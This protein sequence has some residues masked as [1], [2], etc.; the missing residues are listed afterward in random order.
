MINVEAA[1]AI[2]VMVQSKLMRLLGSD[3]P[4]KEMVKDLKWSLEHIIEEFKQQQ[5]LIESQKQTILRLEREKNKPP[6]GNTKTKPK[7][8]IC[9]VSQAKEAKEAKEQF[10][11]G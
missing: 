7:S 10:Y 6:T 9:S 3:K 8:S 1:G 5:S 2:D 11:S 4:A